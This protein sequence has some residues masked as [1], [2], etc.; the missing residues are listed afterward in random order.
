[1][2]EQPALKEDPCLIDLQK[3]CQD[4]LNFVDSPDYYADNNYK[5]YIFET[6]MITLFEKGVFKFIN[7]RMK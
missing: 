5:Q 1:M 4:Y 7:E 2:A 3:L 6:A